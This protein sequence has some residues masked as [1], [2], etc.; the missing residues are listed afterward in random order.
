MDRPTLRPIPLEHALA[1]VRG[2]APPEIVMTMKAG[3]WDVWLS[4][5]YETGCVLLEMDG[6]DAPCRA[7]QRGGPVS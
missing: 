2:T 6:N 5:S 1:I 7:F 4:V 3:Q